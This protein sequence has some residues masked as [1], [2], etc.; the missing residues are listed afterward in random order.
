MEIVCYLQFGAWDFGNSGI[1]V[2]LW[3]AAQ[4]GRLGRGFIPSPPR[5]APGRNNKTRFLMPLSQ[6]ESVSVQKLSGEIFAQLHLAGYGHEGPV[7]FVPDAPDIIG[8]VL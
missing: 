5:P 3:L 7:E 6:C 8:V 2:A 4:T 1:H